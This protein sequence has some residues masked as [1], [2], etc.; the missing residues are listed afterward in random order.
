MTETA[1]ASDLD[2]IHGVLQRMDGTEEDFTA[3]TLDEAAAIS[4]QKAKYEMTLRRGHVVELSPRLMRLYGVT[5][6]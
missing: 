4:R 5:Q 6:E 1:L 3:V 2:I